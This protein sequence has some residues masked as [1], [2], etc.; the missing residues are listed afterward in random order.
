MTEQVAIRGTPFQDLSHFICFQVRIPVRALIDSKLW[1][2]RDVAGSLTSLTAKRGSRSNC[3]YNLACI[4][5][6]W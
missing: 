1:C 2:I 3:N 6:S 5:G 4:Y